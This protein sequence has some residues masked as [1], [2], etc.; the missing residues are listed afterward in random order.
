MISESL[1]RAGKALAVA[2]ARHVSGF[3]RGSKR[4][5][6]HAEAAASP[7]RAISAATLGSTIS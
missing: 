5:F 7:E 4:Y 2:L 6:R 1:C 3:G